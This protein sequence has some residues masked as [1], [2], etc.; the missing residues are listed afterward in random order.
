MLAKKA[1]NNPKIRRSTAVLYKKRTAVPV[2]GTGT[3]VHGTAHLCVLVGIGKLSGD[4]GGS[5]YGRVF[6]GLDVQRGPAYQQSSFLEWV[7]ECKNF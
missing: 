3:F 6:T 1:F 4:C 5:S 2:L 7:N